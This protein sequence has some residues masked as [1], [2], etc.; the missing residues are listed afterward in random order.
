MS[1]LNKVLL[2]GHLGKDPEIRSMQN[3]NRV[4]NFSLATSESWKDR[5]SGARKDRTTWHKIV[6][7]DEH[8]VKLAE[9]YLKKGSRIY[10]EGQIQ[11]RK[12]TDQSGQDK[13]TTEVVLNRFRGT[14]TMLDG[15][16]E[17]NTP[18]QEA[19]PGY[20][21]PEPSRPQDLDDEVPF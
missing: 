1:G 7:F 16:Q 3:G 2:I 13:Y 19:P 14:L 15:K 9:N 8:L 21:K 5:E 6:V 17:D 4:A 12:W 20:T 10:L 18:K 11:E